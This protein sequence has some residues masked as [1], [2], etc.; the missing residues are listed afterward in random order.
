MLKFTLPPTSQICTALM[1]VMSLTLPANSGEW[2]RK[3][4][5]TADPVSSACLFPWGAD[6]TTPEQAGLQAETVRFSNRHGTELRGWYFTAENST[7]TIL[8][9]MGNTGNVS[10]MLPYANIL[11]QGGF[12]VLLFD[13]SGFGQSAGAASVVTLLDD[14]HAALDYLL[15]ERQRSLSE[16]G[17]FGVSLGSIPAL[18]IAADRQPAAVAVEDVFV[19]ETEINR[20]LPYRD[21]LSTLEQ[22]ALRSL[23]T[24]ILPKVDPRRNAARLKC[25]LLLMHGV[26]DKLLPPV[27]SIHVA[28]SATGPTQVWLMDNTGHAPDSLEVND[29]EYAQQ[30][31]GFFDQAFSNAMVGHEVSFQTKQTEQ[32]NRPYEVTADVRSIL[33]P[34]PG[35]HAPDSNAS[36]SNITGLPQPIEIMFTDRRGR[37]HCERRFLQATDRVQISLSFAPTDAFAITAKNIV[38][39]DDGRWEPQYSDYARTMHNFQRCLASLFQHRTNGD[40]FTYDRGAYFYDNRFHP[41]LPVLEPQR[42]QSVLDQI[43]QPEDIPERLRPR[44]ARLLARLQCWPE[45]RCNIPDRQGNLTCAEL[46]LKYCPDEVGSYYELGN[47]RIELGFSDSVVGDALFQLAASR[48]QQGRVQEAQDLLRYHLRVLPGFVDTNLT[49]ERILSISTPNDLNMPDR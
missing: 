18:T 44:Y 13:Y 8:F 36:G 6:F 7:H 20:W 35:G 12:D 15:Q 5:P 22:L 21:R 31:T 1:L 27:G 49:E 32:P 4:R 33:T 41:R 28:E 11:Q 17:L 19:P 46:M 43:P 45:S 24:L 14:T 47:A 37:F 25:P 9:C 29:L 16:I 26:Q 42:L 38:R 39:T 34:L 48:L 2:D 10:L 3:P 30:L 23:E 40:V